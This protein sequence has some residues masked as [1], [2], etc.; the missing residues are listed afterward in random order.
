VR[1]AT[2]DKLGKEHG[3][4]AQVSARRVLIALCL[5]CACL[6]ASAQTRKPVIDPDTREGLLIQQIQQ[7]RDPA[8]KLR[9]MEQFALNYPKHES[10]CWIYDQLIPAYVAVKEWD[11]TIRIAD[12]MLGVVN[13]FVYG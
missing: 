12:K 3:L 10:I 9:Y 11:Q 5:G 8:Q 1:L 6:S 2:A 4:A 13:L 7:E